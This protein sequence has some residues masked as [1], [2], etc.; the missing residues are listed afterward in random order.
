M[1]SNI[2]TIQDKNLWE[3]F[4]E[5]KD[6]TFLQSW[7]WGEFN[8]LM[9]NKIFR[10]GV[11]QDQKLAGVCL[12]IKIKAKRGTFLQIAH[13]P[14]TEEPPQNSLNTL[15]AY[16]KNLAQEK[17]CSFLRIG[18]TMPDSPENKKFFKNL[19]FIDAPT[20]IHAETT[21]NL[22]ID[23][24]EEKLL[25][26][27][28]KTTRY[29][30]RKDL[31]INKL[32]IIKNTNPEEVETFWELQK[33]VLAKHKFT[34]FPKIYLKNQIKAFSPDD[35]IL[36][37]KALYQN[38]PQAIAVIV[39]YQ[40]TAYYHHG[41]TSMKYPKI[42]SSYLLL[43]EAIKEAKKRGCQKF[44]FWGIA[45]TDS[46]KHPWHGITL[47][48]TGFGGYREDFLHAQD[49]PLKPTYWLT[50]LFEVLRRIKRGL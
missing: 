18:S 29:L 12:A 2:T 5:G 41:A 23:K 48:K 25:A 47:F 44:N 50:H 8:Q 6:K 31:K 27:M 28:R 32:K 19:G 17:N 11:Y 35:Q 20:H 34:P 36:V 3:K 22:N 4:L 16:L 40:E 26:E 33:D 42:P 14:I 45:P 15:I 30:I 10:L 21:W 39:F 37:F 43:W 46:P 24:P 49:L 9:G 1:K 7:N 13:G 38:Q